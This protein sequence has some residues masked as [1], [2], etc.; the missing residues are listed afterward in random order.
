METISLPFASFVFQTLG[1]PGLIFIIWW[2]D[3]KAQIK[4][5]EQ[6]LAEHSKQ[7]ALYATE[8]NKVLTQYRED[9]ASMR[10]F[11]ESNVDLVKDYDRSLE[12]LEKL[13]TEVLGV[14]SLNTQTQ[15]HLV[16]SIRSNSF[17]PR[18]REQA[19]KL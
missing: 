7:R 17:C 11:Y 18:V 10:R 19:G 2:W 5:R 6:D 1:L 13:T 9:M 12:R 16:D 15:T 3:H 14:I 8:T 4:Q